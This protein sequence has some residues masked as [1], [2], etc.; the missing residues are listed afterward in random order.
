MCCF[1]VEVGNRTLLIPYESWEGERGVWLQVD[2]ARTRATFDTRYIA[3]NQGRAG[4]S[5]SGARETKARV[6]R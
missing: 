5:I 3:V 4:A 1:E 6:G 2:L